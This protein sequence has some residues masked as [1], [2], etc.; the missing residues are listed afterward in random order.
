MR[1]A[2]DNHYSPLIATL[3]RERGHEA[4]AAAERPWG[5]ESD[6]SVLA[7][8]TRELRALLTN[9]VG[10][11][12]N[13]ARSWAAAGRNHAGLIFTSDGNMPRTGNMVGRYVDALD[14]L[15]AENRSDDAF[16]SRIHWL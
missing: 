1:L 12:T 13:I 5:L 11:F 15:L 10:D 4:V 3:L 6:E 14:A 7:V 9:D 2:L 8:C 16:T